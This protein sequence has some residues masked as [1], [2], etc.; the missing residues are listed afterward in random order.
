MIDAAYEA[1]DRFEDAP[2]GAW[3]G[4]SSAYAAMIAGY[5]KQAY[6]QDNG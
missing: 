4:L 3:C 1:H 6:G 5:A 2:E